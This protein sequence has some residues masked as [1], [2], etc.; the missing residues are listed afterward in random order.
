MSKASFKR[1]MRERSAP[2]PPSRAPMQREVAKLTGEITA[3]DHYIPPTDEQLAN[4]VAAMVNA[5]ADRRGF[6]VNWSPRMAGLALAINPEA[7]AGWIR[8]YRQFQDAVLA[9]AVHDA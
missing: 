5:E 2:L 6:I 3:A 8:K 1:M 7:K 4:F 9:A